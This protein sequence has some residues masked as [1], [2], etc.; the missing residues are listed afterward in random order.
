MCLAGNTKVPYLHNFYFW[1]A[2][3]SIILYGF[4]LALISDSHNC[5]YL[6]SFRITLINRDH[7]CYHYV[8]I[9]R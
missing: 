9:D 1:C 7:Q 6:E 4:D 2:I 8:Q 5:M 3:S